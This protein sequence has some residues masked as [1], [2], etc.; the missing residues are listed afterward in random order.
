MKKKFKKWIISLVVP[1]LP[2][3]LTIIIVVSGITAVASFFQN[4][5][6]WGEK[7][8]IDINNCSIEELIEAV[9]D[10]DIFT[11]EVLE[12]MMIDRKSLKYLLK[13]VND[14]NKRD[15]EANISVELSVTYTVEEVVEVE[16]EKDENNE[17]AESDSSTNE[18]TEEAKSD[19]ST[20]ESESDVSKETKTVSVTYT[21]DRY[22]DVLVSNNNFIRNY[23]MD[24]QT[25]YI[26]SILKSIN[27]YDNWVP[28]GITYDEDGNEIE[29]EPSKLSKKD[30]DNIID[31]FKPNFIYYHNVV[32]GP[33][34]YSKGDVLS[35][36]HV[37]YSTTEVKDGITYYISGH[38][39]VSELSMVVAPYYIDFYTAGNISTYS[40]ENT[41]INKI[42]NYYNG[43]SISHFMSLMQNLPGGENVAN[44]YMYVFNLA[45]WEEQDE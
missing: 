9:D 39:P 33:S 32:N 3:F 40:L 44:S 12:E 8:E 35:V 6:S 23:I 41:F 24:W 27:N 22:F 37:E 19:S 34:S 26:M 18:S 10:K 28:G 30:I 13:S 20:E 2:T 14:Y 15:E 17:G 42:N 36:P 29:I 21:E 4:L 31:D 16:V 1:L 11:K 25:I 38:I 7:K 43:F 5:F 45:K